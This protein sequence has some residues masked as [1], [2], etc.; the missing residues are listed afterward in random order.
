MKRLATFTL[1]AALSSPFSAFAQWGFR[2]PKTYSEVIQ[3]VIQMPMDQNLQSRASRYGLNVVNLTWEDT[4]RYQGS[5]VGPNISDLTL[6][7]RERHGDQVQTHLLPVIRYPNFS[8]K[9]GD[10]PADKIWVRMG[11]QSGGEL[12]AVPLTE[13]LA[14][15]KEYLHDADSLKGDGNL[16]AKRD[17]HFLVSAQHVFLPIPKSG[18]AEFNPVLF[19]YQS[20]PGAPGVLTLLITREGT[21][22]TI[23]DNSPGDQSYQGWGQQLFFNNKGQ[24]TVFTAERKSDVKA[25]IESGKAKPSDE[26]ALEEGADMMMIV[27]IPL[28]VPQQRRGGFGGGWG[29]LAPAAAGPAAEAMA[30]SAPPMAARQRSDVEQAVLGHGDDLGPFREMGG[31]ALRRDSRFPIRITVQFYKAT[32]NGVISDQDLADAHKQIQQVYE[33][34]D[35]VGSL[36]V[37]ESDQDRPTAWQKSEPLVKR[38]PFVW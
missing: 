8:D 33:N 36:V 2:A 22:A 3:Q 19:N 38:M 1:A 18:K 4:G 15:L 26:G 35:Y 21:S 14:N 29:G 5:S 24:K 6:Q 7:V 17:T 23:I 11:N 31:L 9:T 32:S 20:S 25:R 28:V 30:D 12:H 13:V 34:A 37:P 27:Q 16:L 10:V